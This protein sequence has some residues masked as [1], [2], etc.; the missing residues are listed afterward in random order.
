M[1]KKTIR[2]VIIFLSIFLITFYIYDTKPPL[3][4]STIGN[5]EDV[6]EYISILE[7]NE[8]LK[9][10][11]SSTDFT[12]NEITYKIYSSDNF[13]MDNINYLTPL[14]S[15]IIDYDD[16]DVIETI[17]YNFNLNFKS[18]TETLEILIR[19]TL[20]DLTDRGYKEVKKYMKIESLIDKKD[21]FKKR[22]YNTSNKTI[23][24]EYLNENNE[25]SFTIK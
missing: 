10:I 5:I 9:I 8:K 11:V 4:N 13:N 14:S 20:I 6:N 17:S 3:I 1:V 16:K 23:T 12:Q 22:T 25:F 7:K 15:F 24:L 2:F 19:S 18:Y 21:S